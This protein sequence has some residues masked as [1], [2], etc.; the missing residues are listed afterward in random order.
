MSKAGIGRG[1][2]A[3]DIPNLL[4]DWL[5]AAQANATYSG[6]TG[7]VKK[8]KTREK[9]PDVHSTIIPCTADNPNCAGK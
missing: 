3:A 9:K 7:T 1:S 5:Y 4:F 6:Q 8:N 2:E